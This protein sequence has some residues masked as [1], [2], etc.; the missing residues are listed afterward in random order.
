MKCEYSL[1]VLM[2]PACTVSNQ[3][4]RETQRLTEI[5]HL[6]AQSRETGTW[7]KNARSSSSSLIGKMGEQCVDHGLVAS[8]ALCFSLL[9]FRRLIEWCLG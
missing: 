7:Y 5:R 6:P 9:N 1:Q 4:A 8:I 2:N 3:R